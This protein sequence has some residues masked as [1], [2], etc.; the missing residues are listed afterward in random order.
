MDL[1]DIEILLC[2][3]GYSKLLKVVSIS[4]ANVLG[5]SIILASAP[6][7]FKHN[8]VVGDRLYA[9][10]I[11]TPPGVYYSGTCNLVHIYFRT[12]KMFFSL[13]TEKKYAI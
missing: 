7:E 9:Y 1:D 6:V 8:F 4:R 10:K 3:G 5:Q 2:D 12:D 13:L 11:E